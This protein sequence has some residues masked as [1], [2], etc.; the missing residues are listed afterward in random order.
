MN[1]HGNEL[2]EL[3]DANDRHDAGRPLERTDRH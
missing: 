1:R 3:L 2:P